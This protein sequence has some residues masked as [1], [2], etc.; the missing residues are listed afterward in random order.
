MISGCLTESASGHDDESAGT[1]FRT[2]TIKNNKGFENPSGAAATF[3]D[4]GIV[5]LD[6]SFTEDLGTNG[7]TCITCHTEKEGWT[8]VPSF[9]QSRFTATSGLD[10]LFRPVDGANSPLM[11]VSTLA[12]RQQA[13]SL[14]LSRGVIR[15]GIGI[16]P[17]AQFELIEVDDPYNYASAAELSLF[18]R[19]LPS[20]NLAF[21]P[22]VMWDGRVTGATLLD[23]LSDQANGATLGHA[24]ALVPLTAEQREE[25]VDF[26]FGLTHAQLRSTAAGKLTSRGAQGGPEF[27]ADLER[28]S[29]PF[30]LFDAWATLEVDPQE[31]P[32]EQQI[33]L[34]RMAVV[35]GQALFNTAPRANGGT[36]SGC[37]SVANVGTNFNGTFFDVGVSAPERRSP[38]VPLYTLRNI[39]TGEERSTTDPGRALITG[40]WGDVDRFKAPSLRGLAARAPY[41]HDGSAA[42][43]LDVVHFYESALGFDFTTSEENDLVAFMS[44]L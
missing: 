20:A 15:V 12:A 3:S 4:A 25:I 38:S 11:D 41:F 10:P 23:A 32:A 5:D 33:T 17:N 6:T 28:T 13:Y 22:S 14:L 37:H 19:P 36:C 44:V 27:L 7:R 35:R 16:P 29:G 2:S 24:E 30:T 9:V 43:L 40:Q 26:E 18:R 31:S 34:Y 1:E 39:A 42:T 21:V 8:I